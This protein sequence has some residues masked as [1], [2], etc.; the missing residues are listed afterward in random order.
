LKTTPGHWHYK[1]GRSVA[2]T[3]KPS[4]FDRLLCALLYGQRWIADR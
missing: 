2:T 4:L 1:D 3:H